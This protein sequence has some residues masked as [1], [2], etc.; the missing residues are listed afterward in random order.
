[1]IINLFLILSFVVP[2][3]GFFILHIGILR[4]AK[5]QS[6]RYAR[7]E[8]GRNTSTVCSPRTICCAVDK[9]NSGH[10]E[11]AAALR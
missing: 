4:I 7:K 6:A 2:V 10:H 8:G 3:G 11:I 1:M 5:D 9:E